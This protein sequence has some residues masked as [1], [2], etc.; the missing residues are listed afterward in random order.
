MQLISHLFILNKDFCIGLFR[1][2]HLTL[3]T[4]KKYQDICDKIIMI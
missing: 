1:M 4:A 2:V 3:T